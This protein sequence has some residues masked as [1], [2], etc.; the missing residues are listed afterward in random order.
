MSTTPLPPQSPS[1]QGG[2]FSDLRVLWNLVTSSGRGNSHK[3]RLESFYVGQAGDYDA[4]RRRLLRGRERLLEALAQQEGDAR[5]GTWIDIGGGTGHNIEAAGDKVIS[6]FDRVVIL[7]LTPSLLEVARQRI[8]TRGWSNVVTLEADATNFELPPDTP[9][10]RRVTFSYSLTMIPDWFAAVDRAEE[11]LQP[12][13]FLGAVDFYISR[14]YPLSGSVAHGWT[15]RH[16]WPAWFGMDNVFLNPDH[17]PYLRNRV[18][19]RFLE[20]NRAKVP[21][22][23]MVRVPYYV[24]VGQKG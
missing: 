21:Y 1:P 23:P 7:D 11:L 19:P 13:G 2:V 16:C 9:P 6:S 12:K 18:Q 8:T 20:E 17:I 3:E 15:T 5:G 24:F 22:L 14:K 10:I 4:F